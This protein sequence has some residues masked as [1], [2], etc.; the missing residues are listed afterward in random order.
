MSE[1][2][3]ECCVIFILGDVVVRDFFSFVLIFSLVVVGVW[4]C[5]V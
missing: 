5:R 4:G 1:V 2:E 3:V